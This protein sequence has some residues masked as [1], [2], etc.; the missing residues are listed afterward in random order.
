ME[1]AGSGPG[2]LEMVNKRKCSEVCFLPPPPFSF[3]LGCNV[4]RENNLREAKKKIIYVEP[5]NNL[6]SMFLFTFAVKLLCRHTDI[7]IDRKEFSGMVTL[8]RI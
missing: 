7:F 1:A 8:E 2:E 5:L 6:H 4:K 3:L